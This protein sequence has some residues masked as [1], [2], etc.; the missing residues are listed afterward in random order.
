MSTP[1][2]LIIAIA[3]G[4]GAPTHAAVLINEVAWMGTEESYL[5]NW[6]ELYNS[7]EQ[8]VDITDWTLEI[9]DTV[10]ELAEGSGPSSVI[11]AGDYLVL[12]R[13]TGTCPDP[14]PEVDGWT[15]TMGNLPNSGATLRLLRSDGSLEDQVAGGEDWEIIGGDND[16][17][18]T[19]QRTDD[20]WITATPTPGEANAETDTTDDSTDSTESN[21]TPEVRSAIAPP[22]QSLTQMDSELV[23]TLEAPEYVMVRQPVT[24]SSTATG[25]G[26]VVRESLVYSWN[27]GDTQT[28]TERSPTHQFTHPGTYV[29][30]LQAEYQDY[31]QV[32]RH[33]ITVLPANLSV[34]VLDDGRVVVHN[35]AAYE[36]DVSGYELVGRE[37]VAFPPHSIILP[38]SSVT[39]PSSALGLNPHGLVQLRD[40]A[41]EVV[42]SNYDDLH[43]STTTVQAEAAVPTGSVRGAT[44]RRSVAPR[45]PATE[46]NPAFTFAAS[47]TE[48]PATTP[49]PV[50]AD[51]A[52]ATAATTA[53]PTADTT[54]P[55][56]D[57]TPTPA[58][59]QWP[60]YALVGLLLLVAGILFWRPSRPESDAE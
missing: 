9:N 18:Q 44:E 55:P 58:T 6:I 27:F 37:R 40:T 19:A 41:G 38:R 33:E 28:S 53:T 17:K 32:A 10:R 54:T 51:T 25:T 1:R 56:Q 11:A 35:D 12:K 22:P 8:S 43:P 45:T 46:E 59:N 42:A 49:E 50:A 15:L 2:L 4:V 5:C 20:G 48:R 16:S 7:G 60:Y 30:T 47:D 24:F 13:E 52:T 3:L 34:A 39:V 21:G 23:L 57:N 14:V 29:V 36:A 31:T 26:R